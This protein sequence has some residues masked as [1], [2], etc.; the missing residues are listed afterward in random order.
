L[1]LPYVSVV[2]PAYNEEEN[3]SACIESLEGTKYPNLEIIVVD[4]YSRDKT[5]EVA[6]R[7]SVKVIKRNT[8]GGIAF[9]R[10]D[11]LRLARSEITAFVDADCTVAPD[12]LDLLT[13]D[14]ADPSIAGVG[15]V[16]RT[17]KPGRLAL[18]R[19]FTQREEYA[20]AEKPMS[21]RYL[22]GGNSAYRTRILR[23]V[24][25]FNPAFAQPRG[26]EAL[27]L[28]LRITGQG[29]KLIG[30]PRAVVWHGS[31]DSFARWIR[32][33]FGLGYSSVP[34]LFG[35][36]LTE[37]G[38][39]QLKQ[40]GLIGFLAVT[41]MVI[42]RILPVVVFLLGASGILIYEVLRATLLAVRVMRAFN[43]WSYI[44][45]I[46]VELAVR[47]CMY[48]GLV[49]GLVAAAWKY[50]VCQVRPKITERV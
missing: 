49:C 48:A 28:G 45:M 5:V 4:D 20:E 10:N 24:G 30:E 44:V 38:S 36:R 32:T 25:G 35:G 26:H 3:I 14:F 15:G 39:I 41:V 6:S 42:L 19:S 12:W 17:K 16:I 18:Y 13:C 31:E 40:I 23:E 22:P 11:G 43:N 47:G 8:R 7:Y 50:I 21:T 1:T 34:F 33:S 27:E 2:I 29:Y 46:P 9:A 37:F